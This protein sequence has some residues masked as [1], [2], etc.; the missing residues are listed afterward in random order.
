MNTVIIDFGSSRTAVA[1]LDRNRNRIIPSL[2]KGSPL[3][4]GV[5]D[6]LT[7][8]INGVSNITVEGAN[9]PYL[10]TNSSYC[11]IGKVVVPITL[12]G[13]LMH[14]PPLVTCRPRVGPQQFDSIKENPAHA[15]EFLKALTSLVSSY[16]SPSTQWV[17]GASCGDGAIIP[18]KDVPKLQASHSFNE[19]IAVI[20]AL[21][22]FDEGHVVG[23]DQTTPP[24]CSW[25]TSGVDSWILVLRST[26]RCRRP[27]SALISRILAVTPSA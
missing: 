18:T 25:R 13:G 12:E 4:P 6:Q 15:S 11:E 16:T 5:W 19:A 3:K 14:F 22:T 21:T 24:A 17:V 1:I 7:N 23:S 8:L 9:E 20:A 2:T 27:K 10:L 26:L